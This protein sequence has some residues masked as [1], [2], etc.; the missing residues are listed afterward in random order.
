LNAPFGYPTLSREID[1]TCD[2]AHDA[3]VLVPSSSTG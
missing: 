1:Y 2:A 3:I